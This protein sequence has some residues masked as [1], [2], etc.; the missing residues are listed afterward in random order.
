VAGFN[1][2][3]ASHPEATEPRRLEARRSL[4]AGLRVDW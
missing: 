2:L 4:Q 1:L 3:D